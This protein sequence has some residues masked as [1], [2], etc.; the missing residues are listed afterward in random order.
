MVGPIVIGL[1]RAGSFVP[2]SFGISA[3]VP[4][5]NLSGLHPTRRTRLYNMVTKRFRIL[6]VLSDAHNHALGPATP[7][8][9]RNADLT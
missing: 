7:L 4:R 5:V 6:V 3:A 2:L 1:N 8:T 9:P